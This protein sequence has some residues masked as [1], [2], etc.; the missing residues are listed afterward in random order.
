M[1]EV[2]K[3]IYKIRDKDL[4]GGIEDMWA[5]MKYKSGG[6]FAMCGCF[7]PRFVE[8]LYKGNM[9]LRSGKERIIIN[10]LRKIGEG[11]R[12][13]IK[14]YMETCEDAGKS[15]ELRQT[16]IIG[17]YGRKGEGPEVRKVKKRL[18]KEKQREPPVKRK[19]DIR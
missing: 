3:R 14:V 17:F 11:S 10:M 9:E 5:K 7:Q 2:S 4:R 18:Y 12:E 13:M 8:T 16:N 15:K 6:E 1:D 19:E